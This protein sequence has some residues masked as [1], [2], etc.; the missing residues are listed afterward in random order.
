[1]DEFI[2]KLNDRTIKFRDLHAHEILF[3]N[4]WRLHMFSL[5]I[6]YM[7]KMLLETG[8]IDG[9][10]SWGIFDN[11]GKERTHLKEGIVEHHLLEPGF[12]EIG[13]VA[14]EE[15][16]QGEPDLDSSCSSTSSDNENKVMIFGIESTSSKKAR[17][18]LDQQIYRPVDMIIEE[19]ERLEE[20][21]SRLFTTHQISSLNES[22]FETVEEDM[23]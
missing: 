20:S 19:Q 16:K 3:F 14:A 22:Y 4:L 1:M 10:P 11:R 8:K 6:V 5:S 12:Q 17:R 23:I 15:A 18:K 7:E 13:L 21:S 9:A 2:I